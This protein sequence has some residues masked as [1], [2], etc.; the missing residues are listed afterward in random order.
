MKTWVKILLIIVAILIVAGVIFF[1]GTV[2][3]GED[4]SSSPPPISPSAGAVTSSDQ[5]GFDLK[6]SNQYYTVYFHKGDE[7]NADK[8]LAVLNDSVNNLY[9]KYLGITPKDTP[10]YLTST[11]EEYVKVADFPGGGE[12]VKVGDGSAPGGKIY[13]YKPFDDPDKGEGVIVHEGTHAALWNFLGGGQNMESLS[14]FLNEGLAYHMEY[15]YNAGADYKPMREIYF[16]D[17]MKKAANSGNPSLMSLDELGQNCEG[18]VSD[19][20]KDGLCRGQGTFIVWYMAKNYGDPSGAEASFWSEFLIDLKLSKDW[21]QSLQTISG[22]SIT[23][24]GTEIDSD[25]KEKAR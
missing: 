5:S 25:L 8:T 20:T 2:K 9:N 17:L 14:G 1:L 4:I 21:A 10:V 18:Y 11:V 16:S 19:S 13:L 6:R 7:S 23:D 15:I 3:K 24:L 22:K 12:N